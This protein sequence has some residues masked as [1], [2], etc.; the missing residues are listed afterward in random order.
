MIFGFLTFLF[1]CSED[2]SK[3]GEWQSFSLHR[4]SSVMTDSYHYTVRKTENG[5]MTV[6]GFCYDEETEYRMEEEVFLISPTVI[7][8]TRST[9]LPI[10]ALSSSIRRIP[11]IPTIRTISRRLPLIREWLR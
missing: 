6:T 1:G 5:E 8:T 4:T 11:A 7:I 10:S 2:P 9:N 3:Y